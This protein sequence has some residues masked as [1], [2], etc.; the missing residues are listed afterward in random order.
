M[1]LDKEI[2]RRIQKYKDVLIGFHDHNS[3]IKLIK[4]IFRGY[5]ICVNLYP[6]LCEN[7]SEI[8]LIPMGGSYD[9]EKDQIHLDFYHVNTEDEMIE[10][11][12]SI[13]NIFSFDLRQLI[14]HEMVHRQQYK[15]RMIDFSSKIYKFEKDED[16]NREYLSNYDEIDAYAHDIALEILNFYENE[17]ISQVFSAISQKKQCESYKVYHQSF[18]GTDWNHIKNRLLKK[19]Y[20]WVKLRKNYE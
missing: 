20:L 16:G 15:S 5:K 10:V 11:N 9:E 12:F 2:Q 13:W 4:K 7:C 19:T 14:Q 18:T 3:F 1:K 17:D 6:L 8:K